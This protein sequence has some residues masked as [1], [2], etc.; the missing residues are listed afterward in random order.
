MET[1]NINEEIKRLVGLITYYNECYFQKGIS[2]ISDYAYDQLLERL[3]ELEQAYPHLKLPGS[4]TQVIGER[5]SKGFATVYHQTP[6]RSLAKTY[7]EAEIQQFVARIKK[8]VPDTTL[9]FI[10]EPK[11]DGVA[12]SIL[13]LKGRLVR[14]VTRGDGEKGDDV[15]DNVRRCLTLPETIQNVPSDSFEVRGEAFMTKALF[16]QLNAMRD[17]RGAPL[18][19]NPRNLAAGTLKALDPDLVKHRSLA[20]YA[21]SLHGLSSFCL[22]QEDALG[23][24]AKW[25]LPVAPTYKVCYNVN[26]IMEYIHYWSNHKKE[27]TVDVDGIVI[28]V[29]QLQQQEMIGA[30]SKSPRWAI[31]YKYQPEMANSILESVTFQVGRTGVVTPVAHFTPISLAGTMVSRASLHNADVLTRQSLSLGD[32][33]FI[34]KGGEIIPKVVGVDLTRRNT[35]NKPIAFIRFCPA[36]ATPLHRA[37]GT[38]A[39]YC[40]N[41]YQCL[42]QLRAAL[43]HFSH[44]KAMDIHTL[45]PKTVDA[46]LQAELVQS[47]ADLYSLSYEAVSQLEGFQE[48][49]TQTLLTNIEASKTRSFDK[50]LFA[51]GIKHV[52]ET[53]AKKLALHFRSM[54]QLQQASQ[55]E[56]L[57]LPD[58][59]QKIVQSIFDYFQDDYQQTIL[60]RL[61]V[62]GLSFSLPQNLGASVDT[63]LPLL[64]KKFVISGNF[65]KFTREALRQLIEQAGG[66]VL[67]SMSPKVDYLIAGAKAGPLKLSRAME[68]TVPILKETDIIN[69]IQ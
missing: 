40:P 10:C 18:W 44:R 23:L 55:D 42:P 32:T 14:V 37:E 33:I 58:I 17:Q 12:L 67:A 43:L 47:P 38:V 21:Y 22:T 49:S 65:Q 54:E 31:A 64:S 36:C 63:S 16:N 25:G 46:L 27:L 20:F 34:E 57:A 5:P 7:S 24:L 45:G 41:N 50:L 69:M 28:K 68:L 3:I 1:T 30:T 13:Y 53:V 19:A 62:A 48:L 60:S 6:M 8:I 2:E 61:Q 9:S 51:L 59:G 29:N 39:Y 56:L 66:K 35:T 15:T 26:Q 52:G 11:I 4:P